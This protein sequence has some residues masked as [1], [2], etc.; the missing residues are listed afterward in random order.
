MKSKTLKKYNKS[1][2]QRKQRKTRK[3]RR[4]PKRKKQKGGSKC[5]HMREN[6]NYKIFGKLVCAYKNKENDLYF[7][8]VFRLLRND[9]TDFIRYVYTNYLTFKPANRLALSQAFIT[10]Q[11]EAHKTYNLEHILRGKNTI[12]LKKDW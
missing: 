5:S 2:K 11:E 6:S 10:F 12:L 7:E 8:I 3:N 4:Q 1:K 9:P